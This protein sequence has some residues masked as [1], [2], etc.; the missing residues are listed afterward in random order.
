MRQ[1][2]WAETG[3]HGL[4]PNP[5]LPNAFAAA[6]H[7][8]GGT[9]KI[10]DTRHTIHDTRACGK[11]KRGPSVIPLI[12]SAHLRYACTYRGPTWGV[13]RVR[14]CMRVDD[15]ELTAAHEVLDGSYL[16]RTLGRRVQ[17]AGWRVRSDT[18]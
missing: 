10:H 8:L 15:I 6:A 18:F 3:N 13:H 12:T 16:V 2:H 4:V 14:T 5:A 17:D 11:P 1:M 7:D 9:Y